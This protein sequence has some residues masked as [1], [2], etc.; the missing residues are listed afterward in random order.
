M[1]QPIPFDP[2]FDTPPR[3]A[4]D[5]RAPSSSPKSIFDSFGPRRSFIIGFAVA[6]MLLA[7]LGFIVLA[8]ALLTGKSITL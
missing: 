1:N 4:S 5:A 7:N 3:T 2:D 6:I 8:W